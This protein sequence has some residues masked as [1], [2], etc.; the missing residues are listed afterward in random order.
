VLDEFSPNPAD[1]NIPDDDSSPDERL[2]SNPMTR[3]DVDLQTLFEGTGEGIGIVDADERFCFINPAGERIFG[4][5]HGELTGRSLMDFLDEGGRSSVRNET[6]VRKRGAHSRYLIEIIRPDGQRR[7][8]SITATPRHDSTGNYIGAFG[9]FADATESKREEEKLRHLN[10]LLEARVRERTGEL[11][12]AIADLHDSRQQVRML[13]AH[14]ES[15]REEE[16]SRVAREIHDQLGQDLTTAKWELADLRK[17]VSKK[18][19]FL[20]KVK[21]IQ[22]AL[23][24]ILEDVRRIARDLGPVILDDLGLKAAIE[25]SGRD[26]EK[27]TG[28]RFVARLEDTPLE[29][30]KNVSKE[31]FRIFQESLTNVARHSQASCVEVALSCQEGLLTLVVQDDG[32]GVDIDCLSAGSFGLLGMRERVVRLM[33]E[34]SFTT[35]LMKGFRIEVRVPSGK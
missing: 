20:Q 3:S 26:F 31:L 33:G 23:D 17:L 4:V 22:E 34:I 25:S 2:G 35:G 1:S 28:I 8:L 19:V 27:R 15:V 5:A 10:D 18:P 32:R 14:L 24:R 13:A 6:D 29:E 12:R 21:K 7:K 9:V 30:H 11:V 16:N